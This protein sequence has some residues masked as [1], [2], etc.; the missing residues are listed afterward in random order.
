MNGKSASKV[1]LGW[2]L[3]GLYSG[4]AVAESQV[5]VYNW[6]DYIGKNT[7]QDF[8]KSPG[9]KVHYD[10]FDS[11]EIVEAKLL[12]G[13]SGYDVVVPSDIFISHFIAA[14][15]IQKLDKTKLS[16]WKNLSPDVL[17]ALSD[18]DPG[19]E[20]AVPYMWSTNGIAYNVDKVREVLGANAPVD[21]WA[22][23]FDLENIK[24]LSSCGVAFLDSPKEVMPEVLTYLGLPPNSTKAEDNKKAEQLMLKIRPFITYFN[25]SKFISDLANG[26]ICVAIS[27]S[28]SAV[29]AADRATEAKNGIKIKY[30]IPKE[31]TA[32]SVDALVIPSDAKNVAEAHAFINYL[33]EPKV[34][35]EASN[36]VGY[37]NANSAADDFVNPALRN[38]PGVYPSDEIRSHLFPVRVLAPNIERARNRSW[39]KIKSGL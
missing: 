39:T 32:I 13:R 36:D 35:A 17:K 26:N 23:L 20:Y 19:N 3:A 7:I 25:S 24:K 33:L 12:T 18:I 16:N 30:S 6:S 37:A 10:T 8:E 1:M 34:I 21:S 22:L 5:N 38:N 29:Q 11:N 28:G 15:A 2:V 27:W 31:G 14:G 9:V 4:L